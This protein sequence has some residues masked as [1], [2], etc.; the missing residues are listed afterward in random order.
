[1]L[2]R[3]G[4][5]SPVLGR[6]VGRSIGL[7]LVV[8]MVGCG[9]TGPDLPVGDDLTSLLDFVADD[10]AYQL[11]VKTCLE[12]AGASYVEYT[13]Y[14]SAVTRVN[15]ELAQAGSSIVESYL[16]P[17]AVEDP[18]KSLSA[19]LRAALT[20]EVLIDGRSY[21][22]CGAYASDVL[23]ATPVE[24]A[25]TELQERY[26]ETVLARMPAD[27]RRTALNEEWGECMR[28]MGFEVSP[29][30]GA[31]VPLIEQ[32]AE[33]ALAGDVTRT[34]AVAFEVAVLDANTLCVH[35]GDI[36]ERLTELAQEYD[37]RFVDENRE[38]I[39]A[40]ILLSDDSN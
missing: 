19:E 22:G 13:A 12:R 25:R 33:Q 40:L 17:P 6:I 10:S 34:D 21:P 16:D 7:S 35:E 15:A 5:E 39:E 36:Q 14:Q 9:S 28:R 26:A 23:A 27:S 3:A 31:Y 8:F 4:P 32:R 20:D 24:V 18:T 1:M 2:I 30:L 29:V 11:A 38:A 37:Q